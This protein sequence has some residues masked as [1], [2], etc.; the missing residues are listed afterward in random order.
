MEKN[1]K[2]IVA[3]NLTELRKQE[4]LTQ[5]ALAKEMNYSDKAVSKWEQGDSLPD[6]ATL[7][8]LAEFYGVTLDYLVSEDPVE[9]RKHLKS[10]KWYKDTRRNR[11]LLVSLTV[12][13]VYLVAALVF[14]YAN[15]KFDYFYWQS[16]LW[17]TP[18]SCLAV[19]RCIRHWK[20]KK[21]L[22][23]LISSVLCWSALLCVYIQFLG[24]NF[25]LV[26]LLGIPIQIII[27]LGY[28]MY[29]D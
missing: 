3:Q 29:E 21:G 25:Y 7:C 18:V 12:C 9:R 16:F 28:K 2:A 13:A 27:L 24:Y 4:N 1:I 23:A 14:T 6:L 15:L 8:R 26:F 22:H 5:T 17:A 20:V 11:I 10:K 19:L